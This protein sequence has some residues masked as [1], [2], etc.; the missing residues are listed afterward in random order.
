M[1][2]KVKM[3]NKKTTITVAIII[4]ILA[5]VIAIGTVVFLKDRGSTEAAEI[6]SN[7]FAEQENG[8][9]GN[10]PAEQNNGEVAGNQGTLPNA[11][12]QANAENDNTIDHIVALI[13]VINITI[14][15]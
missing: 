3:P 13:Q 8:T 14:L 11:G 5:V 9:T 15:L 10:V 2:G 6:E 7:Q 12:E 1:A 4:A